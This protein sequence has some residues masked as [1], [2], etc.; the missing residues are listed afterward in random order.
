MNL[1]RSEFIRCIEPWDLSCSSENNNV[2]VGLKIPMFMSPVFS[3]NSNS[4]SSFINNERNIFLWTDFSDRFVKCRICNF[5][6]KVGHWFNHN[7]PYRI[8]SVLSFFNQSSE[9]VN[10]SFL[11]I[12]I[13][14]LIMW[15]G[16]LD[17][18]EV[19][20]NPMKSWKSNICMSSYSLNS[21]KSLWM[22]VSIEG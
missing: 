18:R 20:M 5:V 9:M 12:F 4:T 19:T 15:Y 17:F 8:D 7:S 14:L 11:L 1:L 6:S 13:E 16:V 2:R 22:V 10:H 21:C 3:C